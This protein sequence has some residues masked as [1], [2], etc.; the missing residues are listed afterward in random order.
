MTG[1]CKGMGPQD[2]L[3]LLE[4]GARIM[5]GYQ[6]VYWSG[7]TRQADKHGMIDPMVTD[8]PGF[9]ARDNPDCIA[10]GSA[11]RTDTLGLVDGARLVLDG[12]GTSPNPDL[13]AL[14]I[15]QGDVNTALDWNG[16]L[17]TYFAIMQKWKQHAGFSAVGLM[18]W[19]GGAITEEEIMRSIALKW[20]TILFNGSGR[21]TDEISQKVLSGEVI[22]DHIYVVNK[23]DVEGARKVLIQC[24][25]FPEGVTR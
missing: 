22:G 21:I 10:L 7:G 11:P 3:G 20:P 25:F 8:L 15:V 5:F 19:N 1:G 17:D 14:L 12:W 2:K 13:E 23:D 16:D 9:V 6:G 18:A 4:V 24:G